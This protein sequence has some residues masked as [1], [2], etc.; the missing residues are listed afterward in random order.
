MQEA[1]LLKGKQA[2][3]LIALKNTQ[4]PWYLASLAKES[5]A[6]YVHVCNFVN[7]CE[8]L[9]IVKNEKHGKVKEVKLTEKGA[10]LADMVAGIYTVLNQQQAPQAPPPKQEPQ[11]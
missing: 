11:T 6:T 2:K 3:I 9:G 4:Q 8:K 10:Q 7:M 1:I 5:G